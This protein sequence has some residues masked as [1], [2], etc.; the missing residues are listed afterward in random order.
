MP[1]GLGS[2]GR[3]RGEWVKQTPSESG[4]KGVQFHQ[5]LV[6]SLLEPIFSSAYKNVK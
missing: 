5:F 3:D 1:H 6:F 2:K 4:L